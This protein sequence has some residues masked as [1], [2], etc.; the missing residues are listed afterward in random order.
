MKKINISLLLLLCL[1]AIQAQ[2]NKVDLLQDLEKNSTENQD[3]KVTAT[4]KSA[5][6]LF[7][8]KDNL[9]SVILI[10]PLGSTVD[11][12]DSDS[13]YLHVIFEEN[14]GYIFKRQ[15]VID[16]TPVKAATV[17]QP[18]KPVQQE[19]PLIQPQISRFSY[20]ETK[21][22]SNI[23]ARLVAG[24]IWKGMSA[25]MVKDS[26]GSPKKI[27][28]VINS[29]VVKEEWIYNNTWLYIENNMLSEWGPIQK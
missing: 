5:S 13:T 28:R 22:G 19:Q 12:V 26:W 16:P 14:E 24:K 8:S 6:R 4:L 10:I 7:E 3:V 15:A 9:T 21:Y 17:M 23:A 18:E 27:N 20:L 2:V 1:V 11:V 29:N 25:E